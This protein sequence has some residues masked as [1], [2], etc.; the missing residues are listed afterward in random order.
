MLFKSL[1][2]NPPPLFL[3]DRLKKNRQEKEKQSAEGKASLQRSK[4]FVNLIFKKDRK[5][6]SRSKSPSHRD[7]GK[8]TSTDFLHKDTYIFSGNDT[9]AAVDMIENRVNFL[10]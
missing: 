6:K 3:E 5:E 1:Y 10:F 2:I 7:K 4:T 9:L 8:S